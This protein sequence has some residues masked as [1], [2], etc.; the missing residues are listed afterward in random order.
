MDAS[1]REVLRRPLYSG[2]IVWN[3]TRKSDKYGQKDPRPRE[4]TDLIE[5]LAPHL[6]IVN[7]DLWA[8]AHARMEADRQRY[9]GR[10]AG[11][12]R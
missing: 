1:V 3:K 2:L 6:E 7:P 12:A 9:S 5:V 8:A 4:A 10:F 11:Q